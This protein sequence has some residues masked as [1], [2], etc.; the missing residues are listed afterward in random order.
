MKPKIMKEGVPLVD[1]IPHALDSMDAMDI[2]LFFF[3][4]DDLLR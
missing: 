3:F 4:L 2:Y 1:K